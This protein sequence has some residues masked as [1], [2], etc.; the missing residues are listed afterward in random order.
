MNAYEQLVTKQAEIST[1]VSTLA[2]ENRT[3]N[4]SEKAQLETLK[5]DVA[6]IKANFESE[7]RKAFLGSLETKQDKQILLAKGD[8][9]EHACKG[10]YPD[11]MNRLSISKYLRGIVTGEWEGAELERKMM[12]SSGVSA[13]IPTPLSSRIIDVARNRAAVFAA[14]AATIP[15]STA[16]L[17]VARELTDATAYWTS[18]NSTI[19]PSDATFDAV[20]FTARKSA[21]ICGLSNE[22]LEDGQGVDEA[23]NNSI[24]AA[25]GLAVDYAALHGSG[26]PP[27]PE[28]LY[29]NSDVNTVTS[30][31][32][33]ADFDKFL[34]AIYQIRGYN[35]NANSVIFNSAVAKKIAGL[36]TGLSGDKTSLVAPADFQA[37]SKFVSNQTPVDIGSPTEGAA[38]FVGQFN[39]LWVGLRRN[40][41]VEVSR[42]ADDAFSKDLT[43]IRAT[44]RGDIQFAQPKAFSV[45]KG[46][47]NL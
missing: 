38:A 19:T 44:W 5:G 26:T 27:E 16:T 29:N 6:A 17:K 36:K 33:I 12:V 21:V 15:M 2:A 20:T 4:D 11:E 46:F 3:P 9:F 24:G 18:E 40:I 43:Y 45:M 34:Q 31:G 35:F 47:T 37:L 10:S 22:L 13:V 14:G 42:E 39:Q 23:I 32:N 41:L 30:V 8:S 7:G 28:G 1:I 25:I